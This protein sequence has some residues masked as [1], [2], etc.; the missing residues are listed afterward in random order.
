MRRRQSGL[1]L[2]ELM[3]STSV[4]T[5]LLSYGV[6]GLLSLRQS[7]AMSGAISHVHAF[8]LKARSLAVTE[9]V[10]ISVVFQS[11]R[12][13]WIGLTNKPKCDCRILASCQVNGR[14]HCLHI[15]DYPLVRLEHTTFHQQVATIDG[16][17]G[18]AV[19]SAG[20][21]V[22]DNGKHVAKII[23]SNIGRVRVCMEQG[24]LG[25]YK[26]C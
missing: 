4:I 7:I 1:T 14:T 11:G 9:Q 23:L 5:I 17:R 12:Q 3:V 8:L 22:L 15:E 20:A 19:G 24:Q 25:R 10:D 2:L 16:L 6:P 26:S 18:F 21:V 13:G